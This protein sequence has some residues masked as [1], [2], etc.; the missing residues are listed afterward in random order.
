MAWEPTGGG[1]V[2]S[3]AA[4]RPNRLWTAADRSRA[5]ILMS[6]ASPVAE[7]PQSEVL[8]AEADAETGERR[9]ARIRKPDL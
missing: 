5:L 7:P 6:N 3:S 2:A 9:P 1:A 8:Y 4:R